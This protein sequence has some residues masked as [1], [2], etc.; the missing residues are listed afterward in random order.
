M[1][2]DGFALGPLGGHV[3]AEHTSRRGHAG[4]GTSAPVWKP[5]RSGLGYLH[6]GSLG[7]GVR[8]PERFV[9]REG[10]ARVAKTWC[11]GDYRL[12]AWVVQQRILFVSGK[13][14]PKRRAG[15]EALPGWVWTIYRTSTERRAVP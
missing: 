2:E 9:K 1:D 5:S 8:P 12:G 7:G 6:E 4:A 10:H 14:D 3:S 11:E 13:L 15:L